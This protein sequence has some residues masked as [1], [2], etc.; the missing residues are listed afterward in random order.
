MNLP[1]T[2]D[3]KKTHKTDA[4]TLSMLIPGQVPHTSNIDHF[5]WN[6]EDP[7]LSSNTVLKKEKNLPPI[8]D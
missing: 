8:T 5:F 6:I 2:E 4:N 3:N 7:L 1:E